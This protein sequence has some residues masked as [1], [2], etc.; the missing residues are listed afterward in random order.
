MTQ[1]K[2]ANAP[3]LVAT[4]DGHMNLLLFIIFREAVQEWNHTD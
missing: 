3:H 1:V 4:A 2:P